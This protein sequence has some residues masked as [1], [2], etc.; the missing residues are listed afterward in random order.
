MK[1]F[2]TIGAT[3]AMVLAVRAQAQAAV[4]IGHFD[5]DVTPEVIF[6]S[7]N[8]NGSFATD[9]DN[10][11][12]LGLRAKLRFDSNNQ[13][14]NIFNSNGDG[15]YTFDAGVAPGGFSFA[16]NSPTTPIWSFEWSVNS[17]YLDTSGV[18]LDGLIYELKIDF[19]PGPGTNF[20]S[21]DP[22]NQTIPDHALGDNTTA[23]GAGTK[24]ADAIAY[25][26]LIANNNV[27]QNSWNMEFFNDAPFNVFDPN[28]NG[29]YD[30]VLTASD[31][32]GVLAST[33]ISVI[34]IPE[35]ASLTLLAL[36]GLVLVGRR[37]RT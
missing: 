1:K 18:N 28:E 21:F 17:D 25:A 14:Q 5:Q 10:G 19:D 7:G 31:M 20:L 24:A 34:V 27:A 6:G 37:R 4:A 26:N 13:P 22:I 11:I 29:V 8:I 9:R 12:E 3:V 36:G 32:S 33:T 16:A 23:N 15:T 35:P 30:F 2:M